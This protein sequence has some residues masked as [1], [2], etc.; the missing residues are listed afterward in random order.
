ME[1]LGIVVILKLCLF[2]QCRVH[3]MVEDPAEAVEDPAEAVEDLVV[4]QVVWWE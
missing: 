4:E 2:V 1:I 3:P